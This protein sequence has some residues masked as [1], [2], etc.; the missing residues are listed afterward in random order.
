ML[1]V[2]GS[3]QIGSALTQGSFQSPWALQS[4]VLTGLQFGLMNL[5]ITF[6]NSAK[7]WSFQASFFRTKGIASLRTSGYIL[8]EVIMISRLI[9][10]FPGSLNPFPR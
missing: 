5:E 7:V 8:K 4:V 6:T 3:R 10:W 9:P 2:L 1:A